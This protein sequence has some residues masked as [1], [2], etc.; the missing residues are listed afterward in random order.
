M[1]ILSQ[2]DPVTL[3]ASPFFSV[4]FGKLLRYMCRLGRGII[5]RN[6]LFTLNLPGAN[7]DVRNRSPGK[8]K[9]IVTLK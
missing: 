8:E 1:T 5:T 7:T 4:L 9:Q 6:L 2:K 3:P